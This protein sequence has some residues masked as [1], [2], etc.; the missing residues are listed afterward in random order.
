MIEVIIRV[1]LMFSF[2]SPCFYG[3]LEGRGG[4]LEEG[5]V[6]WWFFQTSF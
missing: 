3:F 2:F 1:R 4:V 5:G 6:G